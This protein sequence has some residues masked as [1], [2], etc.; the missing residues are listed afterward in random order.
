MTSKDME[1]EIID[2]GWHLNSIK[3]SHHHYKHPAKPGKVTIPFH[4]GRDLPAGTVNS[5]RKQAGLK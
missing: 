5:I 2:D 1:K 3:G 4:P